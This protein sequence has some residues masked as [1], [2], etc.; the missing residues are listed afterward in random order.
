MRYS[1]PDNSGKQGTLWSTDRRPLGNMNRKLGAAYLGD[2]R[3]RFCVWAPFAKQI[4]V[5]IVYPDERLLRLE[6]QEGDYFQTTADEV[7]PG[8][9][10][11][12]RIDEN[13]ERPD[14]ASFFQPLGVHHPSEVVDHTYEWDD[15]HW[16]CSA[17]QDWILYEIH[18]GTYTPEG[19]FEAIVPHLQHLKEL[20]IT[21][22][23]LMPVIQ[24]PGTRN[25]GYDGVFLFAAQNSYGGPVGLKRLV[26][27]C[28]RIGI[29]V[30]LDVVYNHLGPEGNY[31]GDFAPYFTDRYKTPWGAAV[32]FDGADSDEVRRFFIENALYWME[33]FHIDALRLD[34][35]HAIFD[36]SV[37]TFLEELADEVHRNAK[38]L[39]RQVYLIAESDRNEVRLVYPPDRGGYDLDAQWNDDFHH[40]L[41]ALLTRERN[42]YYEDFGEFKQL[43]KACREGFVYSGEY[44]RY[45][46][47]R[48]G[49]SSLEAAGHQLV[50]FAQNHDQ[51]GNRV[52]G[53]RLTRLISFDALKLAAGTTLLSPY[54]PLLFM[55]EE[56]GESSPFQYF[57]HHSDPELIQAVRQGRREEFAAF[58][59]QDEVPDPQADSTF[60]RCKL[61]HSLRDT[62]HHLVLWRFYRELIRLRKSLLAMGLLD[63]GRMEV[64]GDENRKL[65]SFNYWN[66][67]EEATAIFNF[68]DDRIPINRLRRF[69]RWQ[70][71]LD[72]GE[73]CWA[74][75][76]SCIAEDLGRLKAGAFMLFVKKV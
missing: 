63:K 53:E 43:V 10:Y 19:T 6:K 67:E 72:S 54:V 60:L 75:P 74:G 64:A 23:E 51:I 56:Y 46:R 44:S 20:G 29:S 52:L 48:H 7:R 59:W 5:H 62:E 71:L 42:G 27:A 4:D 1:E 49:N 14:P 3:C 69:E 40:A 39:N 24:F 25:W 12:Y 55:G 26:S 36:F 47:R 58:V 8:S 66:G 76:G 61:R 2:G 41:H 13:K 30:V 68:S 32:N 11:F 9:R 57:I 70:K 34:A 38:I 17:L 31:L 37:R 18:V 35:T 33:E 28:H 73:R 45:R 22:I 21:A 50:V 15:S 65:L 16:T